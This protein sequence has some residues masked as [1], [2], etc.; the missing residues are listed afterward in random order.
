MPR[1]RLDYLAPLKS[2]LAK[3][4]K[5]QRTLSP[6]CPEGDLDRLEDALYGCEAVLLEEE[7]FEGFNE[8]FTA[9]VSNVAKAFD[10][11]KNDESVAHQVLEATL[12]TAWDT[13]YVFA[14]G[15]RI[16]EKGHDAYYNGRL[17]RWKQD[18]VE[19]LASLAPKVRGYNRYVRESAAG[20]HPR[21]PEERGKRLL[22]SLVD[23]YLSGW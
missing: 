11:I 14:G 18:Y 2:C 17:V 5:D 10:L 16:L 6:C 3:H 20:I 15:V 1:Y 9:Y 23:G 22:S 13:W 12:A 8:V 19:S 21:Q 7:L 4:P